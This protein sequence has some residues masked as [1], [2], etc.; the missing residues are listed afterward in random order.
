MNATPEEKG[1]SLERIN[2]ISK[3]EEGLKTLRTTKDCPIPKE[4]A[5]LNFLVQKI[6][7]QDTETNQML[8]LAEGI[9]VVLQADHFCHKQMKSRIAV[10]FDRDDV[11]SKHHA[12]VKTLMEKA[13]QLQTDLNE[14]AQKLNDTLRQRWEYAVKSFGLNP[15]KNLYY[16]DE[17]KGEIQDVTLDCLSCKGATRIRKTRQKLVDAAEKPKGGADDT[18]RK[19]S[20]ADGKDSNPEPDGESLVSK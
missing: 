8:L 16:I 2:P 20:D 9:S 14:T 6:A 12:D 17:E 15:V 1:P 19:S 18:T 11:L 13:Q 3:S 10:T 4:A 7:Q 5:H